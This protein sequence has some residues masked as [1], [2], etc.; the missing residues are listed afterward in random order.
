MWRGKIVVKTSERS[1]KSSTL[2]IRGVV[3]F[4]HVDRQGQ[5]VRQIL[6][7]D[8]HPGGGGSS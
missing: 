2:I 6:D 4:I 8:A 3:M 5:V 7:V 1:Y